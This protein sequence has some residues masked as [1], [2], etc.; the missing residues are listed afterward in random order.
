M[1][2]YPNALNRL[3]RLAMEKLV[4]VR[5]LAIQPWLVR[6]RRTTPNNCFAGATVSDT[7]MH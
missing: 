1:Q 5:V 6:A 4:S 3:A 2:A 7:A